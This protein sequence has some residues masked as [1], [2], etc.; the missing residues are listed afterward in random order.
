M[1][2]ASSI[3]SSF[4][5]WKQVKGEENEVANVDSLRNVV[6]ES[7]IAGLPPNLPI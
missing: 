7:M 6:A 3:G 4:K 1:G 2:V 5:K